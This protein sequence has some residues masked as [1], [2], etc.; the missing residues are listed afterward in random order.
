MDGQSALNLKEFT[1]QEHAPTIGLLSAPALASCK[2][3]G[4]PATACWRASPTELTNRG[5]SASAL[6]RK[7]A[8]VSAGDITHLGLG[9]NR[10]AVSRTP[11]KPGECAAWR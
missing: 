6:A 8:T 9:A 11:G 2:L 1:R 4:G 3:R 10:A 5:G 7:L